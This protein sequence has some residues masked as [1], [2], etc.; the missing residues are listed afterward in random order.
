MLWEPIDIHV[1]VSPRFSETAIYGNLLFSNYVSLLVG[2]KSEHITIDFHATDLN[3]YN[4]YFV[5]GYFLQTMDYQK[6]ACRPDG[7]VKVFNLAC[8][9]SVCINNL[10]L[11]G[12][13]NPKGLRPDH[14][15]V[16][17]NTLFNLVN[18]DMFVLSYTLLQPMFM[19]VAWLPSKHILC[20]MD[21][22]M[23]MF[24]LIARLYPYQLYIYCIN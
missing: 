6:A 18:I 2:F 10:V 23:D 9:K 15:T 16:L 20:S 7:L 4:W 12:Y 22:Y 11:I 3:K 14:P 8:W 1:Q 17:P 21:H 5:L 24:T 13:A 19:L